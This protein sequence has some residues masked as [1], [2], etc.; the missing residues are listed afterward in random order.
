MRVR[1]TWLRWDRRTEAPAPLLDVLDGDER[2]RVERFAVA[3]AARELVVGRALLRTVVAGETGVNPRDV[4]FKYGAGGRPEVAWP[5]GAP[6][7]NLT[8]CAGL[9][10]VAVCQEVVGVD[11]ERV[12]ERHPG[13]ARRF[14]HPDE[15]AWVEAGAA[16]TR[17]RRFAAVWTLKEAVVKA[18]GS[19]LGVPLPS[20]AVAGPEGP[21]ARTTVEGTWSLALRWPTEEHALAIAVRGDQ[22]PEVDVVQ[23]T[24][25][26]LVQGTT[27][28][29]WCG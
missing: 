4:R 9:V 10:A 3:S 21:L 8:H 11:A 15:Q 12:A 5:D 28:P 19:G 14:F 13:I 17:W 26:L 23:V 2:A 18:H 20:F 22:A 25:P 1:V 27:R 6:S 7:V 16:D 29:P 24:L